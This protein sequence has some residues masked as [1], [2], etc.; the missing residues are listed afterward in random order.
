[1]TVEE[2]LNFV[3][4]IP[5]ASGYKQVQDEFILPFTIDEVWDLFFEDGARF[6]LVNAYKELGDR[7]T[8]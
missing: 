1:M 6:D 5:L 3:R 7:T 8:K 2:L 4:D